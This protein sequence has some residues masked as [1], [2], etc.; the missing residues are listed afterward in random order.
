[1]FGKAALQ[2]M[3]VAICYWPMQY[4][5]VVLHLTA[6]GCSLQAVGQE[7]EDAVLSVTHTAIGQSQGIQRICIQQGVL[8]RCILFLSAQQHYLTSRRF[9]P[10]RRTS[11][12][13]Q[14][15]PAHLQV[16]PY[17]SNTASGGK[18]HAL[19]LRSRS[20]R[21]PRQETRKVV[22]RTMKV[23][24]LLFLGACFMATVRAQSQSGG[25]DSKL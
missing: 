12:E 15:F 11:F 19:S 25:F 7:A 9:V 2:A 10:F 17:V 3:S 1:M 14:L 6:D 22:G 13:F 21:I 24:I 18:G 23:V 5:D 8:D 16:A 4:R 20:T